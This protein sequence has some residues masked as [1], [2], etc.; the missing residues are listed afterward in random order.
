[1]NFLR[2]RHVE[3]VALLL[4]AAELD[5]APLLAPASRWPAS[6]PGCRATG[7]CRCRTVFSTLSASFSILATVF[8]EMASLRGAIY[9]SSSARAFFFG[10]ARLD[11]HRAFSSSF[12]SAAV[13][14]C[15]TC[16][17]SLL[18]GPGLAARDLAD[19]GRDL[20][21]VELEDAAPLGLVVGGLA[22]AD[23]GGELAAALLGRELDLLDD[24]RVVGDRLLRLAGE[25]HPHRRDVDEQRHRPH[26]QRALGLAQQVVAP[27]GAHDGLGDAAGAALEEQRH[28]VG[29][30]EELDRLV[31]GPAAAVGEADLDLERV[32][33]V[34]LGRAGH[35]GDEVVVALDLLDALLGRRVG[36]RLR[37]GRG[38]GLRRLPCAAAPSPP[39]SPASWPP[40][41][42]RAARSR[43]RS[44]PRSRSRS[45][46]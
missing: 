8:L 39:S 43:R 28:A 40:R 23:E 6:A 7:S 46:S 25:R 33:A 1:M 45:G 36:D 14:L 13:T 11:L 12:I 41:R 18:I 31:G 10:L 29:E 30:A 27:V 24:V 21:D 22:L 44:R 15:A 5:Q 34:H 16:R 3:E 2:H 37:R 35:R 20:L 9:S 26:R 32:A 42:G 4:L 19:G 17:N 38:A